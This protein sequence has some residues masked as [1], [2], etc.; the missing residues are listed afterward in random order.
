MKTKSITQ[1]VIIGTVLGVLVIRPLSTLPH[2][3]DPHTGGVSWSDYLAD[4]YGQIFS[5]NDVGPTLLSILGSI[6]AA[7]LVVM[8]KSRKRKGQSP[9]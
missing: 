7:V 4:V 5:F 6:M 9:E 2:L 8:V 1:A 3:S